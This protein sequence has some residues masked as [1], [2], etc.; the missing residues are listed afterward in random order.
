MA[1]WQARFS[2]QY[3]ATKQKAVEEAQ[4]V[5]K[6][7]ARECKEAGKEP[8]PYSLLELIGRGSFGRVYKATSIKS[9]Q[10]VA[11]KII[12]IDE[13]D[14]LCPGAADT[15]SDVR[16]EVNT[17]K[18][19]SDSGA[20]NVNSVIDTLLVGHFIWIITEHCAGGSVATLMRPTGGLA[21]K[22]IIP[23]LREVAEAIYW[24]RTSDP[25]CF[26]PFTAVSEVIVFPRQRFCSR[27]APDVPQIRKQTADIVG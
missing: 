6:L 10:A 19:L 1:T 25:C 3:S 12:S 13:G 26:Y 8:P 4:T 17:L 15:F 7:V 16:K 14:S 9:R 18:L 23:V 5:Q 22:W 11:V 20:K 27:T 21:E 2:R 24:V